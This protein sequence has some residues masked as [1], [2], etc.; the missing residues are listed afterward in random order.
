M[1]S[2]TAYIQ[3]AEPVQ[4][5]ACVCRAGGDGCIAVQ[6]DVGPVLELLLGL[7]SGVDDSTDQKPEAQFKRVVAALRLRDSESGLTLL[8]QAVAWKCYEAVPPLL[9]AVR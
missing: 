2:G 5:Y 9:D 1:H 6:K 3:S 7:P 8:G 4:H